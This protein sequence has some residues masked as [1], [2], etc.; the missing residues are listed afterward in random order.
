M[1]PRSRR[2][3]SL[4]APP[5]GSCPSAVPS[6]RPNSQRVNLVALKF[7]PSRK[8]PRYAQKKKPHGI[9]AGLQLNIVLNDLCGP[10]GVAGGERLDAHLPLLTLRF[11]L[12]HTIDERV[13]RI[14]AAKTDVAPRMHARAEL[15]DDD[16]AGLDGLARVNLDTP[17]LARTVAAIARRTLAFFVRH[18]VSPWMKRPSGP[19]FN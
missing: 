19:Q 8:R 7:P 18:A 13:N 14:V 9:A 10:C 16:I 2:S 6:A 4:R 5:R 15:A 1:P 3:R 11:V 12:N 17:A